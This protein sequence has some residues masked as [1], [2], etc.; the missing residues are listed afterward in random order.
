PLA[1]DQGRHRTGSAG[2]AVRGAREGLVHGHRPRTRRNGARR[3][4]GVQA[5][6]DNH[7]VRINTSLHASRS[8]SP[9]D[10]LDADTKPL[11]EGC[12]ERRGNPTPSSA[13]RGS[14]TSLGEEMKEGLIAEP[15]T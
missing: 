15:A 2:S 8:T 1:S 11:R 14:K 12:T 6:R 5:G 7:Q 13:K 10:A 3:L 4:D 9:H